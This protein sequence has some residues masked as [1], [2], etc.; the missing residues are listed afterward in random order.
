MN[1]ARAFTAA[2]RSQRRRDLNAIYRSLR[3]P[4]MRARFQAWL[5]WG[6][7][8]WPGGKPVG[9]AG[10]TWPYWTEPRWLRRSR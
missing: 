5:W 10:L 2:M 3:D 8:Y 6:W 4:D 9:V 1:V 7:A